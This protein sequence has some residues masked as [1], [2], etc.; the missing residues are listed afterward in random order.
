V[1]GCPF[2]AMVDETPKLQK[3]SAWNSLSRMPDSQDR[4]NQRT[5]LQ[6]YDR[7]VRA[8]FGGCNLGGPGMSLT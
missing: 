7:R 4:L 5:N 3:S 6:F 8:Q 2:P 1:I